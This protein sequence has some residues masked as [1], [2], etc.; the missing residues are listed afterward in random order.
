LHEAVVDGEMHRLGQGLRLVRLGL[1]D[2]LLEKPLRR[3]AR[4][5]V[6]RHPERT[7]RNVEWGSPA[8]VPCAT[9]NRLGSLSSEGNLVNFAPL[10]LM[11]QR[12]E[13]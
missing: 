11:E 13:T 4:H 10:M 1:L 12:L 5:P 9:R 3:Q 2:L 8:T 7:E 6:L